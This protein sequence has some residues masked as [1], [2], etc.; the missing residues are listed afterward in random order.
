MISKLLVITDGC[1]FC[2]IKE[3]DNNRSRWQSFQFRFNS[4][5]EIVCNQLNFN[6]KIFVFSILPEFFSLCDNSTNSNITEFFSPA[7]HIFFR[8]QIRGLH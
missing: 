2:N 1:R 7:I 5:A 8:L 6:C 3:M 4:S